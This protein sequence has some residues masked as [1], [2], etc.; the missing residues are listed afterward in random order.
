MLGE[1][2]HT[3][4]RVSVELL[5]TLLPF[6]D[7]DFYFCGPP[8]FMESIYKDLKKLNVPD[9][10]VHY[11]FF[12]PG[13]SLLK[14]DP[15]QNEGLLGELDNFQ[16]V[17]VQFIDSE[18]Q[19]VWKPSEG[20]LLELAEKQGLQPAYSCRSGV[21][22]TCSVKVIEGNVSYVDPPLAEP[23][24]GHALLCCAYTGKPSDDNKPLKLDL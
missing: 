6:D 20:T 21:C 7:Y 10:R 22:G 24:A 1:D 15:G 2:F 3:K 16:H 11:E 5:K 18:L 19:A 12:A 8:S 14:E 4:G 23:E 13:A 9:E 17:E